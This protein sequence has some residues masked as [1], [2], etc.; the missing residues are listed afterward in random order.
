MWQQINRYKYVFGD[1]A[2]VERIGG[3]WTMICSG[4]MMIFESRHKAMFEAEEIMMEKCSLDIDYLPK[5]ME[6]FV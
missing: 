6:I 5:Q 3:C 2:V 1:I 4:T